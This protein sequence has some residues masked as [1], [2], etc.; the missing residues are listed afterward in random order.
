M[1]SE[2]S[3]ELVSGFSSIHRRHDLRDLR[4]TFICLVAAL[5]H[6]LDAVR[7]LLEFE[8]FGGAEWMPPE[9]RDHPLQQILTTTH[10]V[11]VKVFSVIVRAPIDVHLPRSEELAEFV[12]AVDATRALRY[13]EIMRDLVSGPVASS[14][15]SVRLP[16]EANR[17]ASFSVYKTDHPAT[18]LAQPFLLVFRTRHIVTLF[19]ESDEQSSAG[20][21]GFSSI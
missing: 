9:E 15:R 20:Y 19:A 13:H 5:F 12:E 17:E 1:A 21:T 8:P 7:E 3:D 4:K 10:G 16:N 18:E 14:P 6:Q 2:D 11:A